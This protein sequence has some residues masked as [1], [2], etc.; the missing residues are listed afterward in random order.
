MLYIHE[1]NM[2]Y[3]HLPSQFKYLLQSITAQGLYIKYVTLPGR[4]VRDV[5][6]FVTGGPVMRDVTLQKL[7]KEVSCH[8]ALHFILNFIFKIKFALRPLP[9]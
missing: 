2:L 6:Q 1:T 5:C 3:I 8:K 9:L 7:K 4:G